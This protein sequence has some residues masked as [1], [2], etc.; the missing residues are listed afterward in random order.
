MEEERE[1]DEANS[2]KQ[3][4]ARRAG[5][6]ASCVDLL[7]YNGD[8]AD[9]DAATPSP[10][11]PPLRPAPSPLS[12]PLPPAAP[13]LS[14]P[15]SPLSGGVCQDPNSTPPKRLRCVPRVELLG[16]YDAILSIKALS[17]LV[18]AITR[19]AATQ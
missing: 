19:A 4:E 9:W 15:T 1:D 14:P 12:P 2:M 5:E 3:E 17:K 8:K 18:H 10:L 13:L 7:Q 6:V 11:T 16:S